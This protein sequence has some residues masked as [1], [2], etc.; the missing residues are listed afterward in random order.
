MIIKFI[1]NKNSKFKLKKENDNIKDLNF[2]NIII[3]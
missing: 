3:L 2:V 1:G